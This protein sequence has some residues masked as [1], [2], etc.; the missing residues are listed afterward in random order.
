MAVE[1]QTLEARFEQI[2][3]NDQNE[4]PAVP[5]TSFHKS[6]VG[7]NASEKNKIC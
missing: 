1:A 6:K 3:I 4:D 5:A 7:I 2:T